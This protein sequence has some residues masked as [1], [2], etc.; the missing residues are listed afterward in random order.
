MR[1]L[2][3]AIAAISFTTSATAQELQTDS[4]SPLVIKAPTQADLMVQMRA[5]REAALL[6]APVRS[7]RDITAYTRTNKASPLDALPANARKVFLDSVTFN[8]KG[9]TGFRYDVLEKHLT[10]TQSFAILSMFGAQH[11]VHMLDES[12]TETV[13][14]SALISGPSSPNTTPTLEGFIPGV[15]NGLRGTSEGFGDDHEGYAC[16]G[17]ATCYQ[18]D[19]S[20]CMSS[21]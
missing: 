14:D 10:P 12:R 7:E 4:Q 2:C 3:A 8:E 21:C 15:T 17:R 20:I 5:E 19:H 11:T 1:T 6:A 16:T 13:L 9:I 18:T